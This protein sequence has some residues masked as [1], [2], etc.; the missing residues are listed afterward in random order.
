MHNN[1]E[2]LNKILAAIQE[3][4][5]TQVAGYLGKAFTQSGSAIS[6]I[7]AYDLE[8]GARLL[9]PVTTIFRN[10][11]PRDVG[12]MGIQANWRSIT[13][14]NPSGMAPGVSEGNRGG[15]VDQ[16]VTDNL[17]AFVELGLENFVTWKAEYAGKGFDNVPA[18]AVTNL[19]RSTME[20]EE[21]VIIGGNGTQLLGTTP[22]PS[23]TPSTTGGTLAAQTDWTMYAVALTYDGMVNS[24]L[25]LGVKLPY[26]RVNT[27]QST[28]LING[29]TA[30]P[31]AA[32][33]STTTG[34]TS[35]IAYTVAPVRGAFGYAW[36]FGR[37]G[38]ER[39]YAI[40]SISAVT[41]TA[42]TASPAQL[43]TALPVTDTSKNTLNFDGLFTQF[44][45]SGSGAYFKDNGALPLTATGS[46]TGGIT[47][48]D[49][50]IQSFYDN[51]RLV[52][53]D[54]YMSGQDQRNAK[55]KILTGNTNMAP[56]FLGNAA[57]GV[58]GGTQFKKYNNP[59]GF[60]QQEL[61]VHV[62][63]FIPQGT[64]MFYSKEIPY[65]LSNVAE[66]VKMKLRYD[67]RQIDWP[68]VKRKREY[69]VYFDGVLQN[70]FPPAF[71]ILCNVANG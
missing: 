11:I 38:S 7:T 17:A 62:H 47:E 54:I 67:Y 6:G 65:S 19:L 26:T 23:A 28:D 36:F 13:A 70:Y 5:K 22:T 52:P 56:F 51:F 12:G 21:K 49:T 40:T 8:Q 18:L 71:G 66:L 45:K 69:G 48:F 27:D 34:A 31:S 59:I 3:A 44:W 63:P 4:Q 42:N 24:T 1:V 68:M 33:T 9:Y 10:I 61:D 55:N 43:F 32:A 41:V 64:I 14:I 53:T 15:A 37:A 2:E 50:A 16:T 30:I 35:S 29:F 39:L 58:M 57:A 46:G 60:G 20:A 25:A